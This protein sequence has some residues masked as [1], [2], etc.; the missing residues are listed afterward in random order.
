MDAKKTMDYK[1]RNFRVCLDQMQNANLE[2]CSPSFKEKYL[3]YC[4]A[5][6]DYVAFVE[7]EI[8]TDSWGFF[9]KGISDGLQLKFDT[10]ER[11][12][13]WAIEKQNVI[14][15]ARARLRASIDE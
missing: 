12:K 15:K 13:K 5:W 7:T 14:D 6:S 1:K 2:K 11:M 4:S 10:Y 9:F 8:P 3:I